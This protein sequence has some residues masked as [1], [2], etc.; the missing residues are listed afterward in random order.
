[1]PPLFVSYLREEA[2]VRRGMQLPREAMLQHVHAA[3]ASATIGS[4]RFLLT[5]ICVQIPKQTNHS[6]CG[7]YL[8]KYVEKFLSD[9][10]RYLKEM[11]VCCGLIVSSQSRSDD[12]CRS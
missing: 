2:R 7:V 11:L 6:D 1:M 12:H 10:E 3:N 5:K 9:P 8:L 4:A